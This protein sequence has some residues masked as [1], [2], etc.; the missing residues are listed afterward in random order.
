MKKRKNKQTNKQ[1]K[2]Q[3]NTETKDRNPTTGF[4]EVKYRV[5]QSKARFIRRF[6][7][8]S[9]SI[10]RIKFGRSSTSESAVEF[11]LHVTSL[12]ALSVRNATPI[13]TSHFCRVECNK[14]YTYL[15]FGYI[16]RLASK[17]NFSITSKLSAT[18]VR[19]VNQQSHFCRTKLN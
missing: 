3:R 17:H 12:V 1:K 18:E 2:K 8:V 14:N 4:R 19:P 6:S 9:N 15:A 11:L 13:Q 7:A 10:K 16:V 5:A